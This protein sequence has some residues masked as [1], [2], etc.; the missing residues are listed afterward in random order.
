MTIIIKFHEG[1]KEVWH[2]MP[3]QDLSSEIRRILWVLIRE[4]LDEIETYE[5]EEASSGSVD[6]VR[7]LDDCYRAA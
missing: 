1:R 7:F 6:A 5:H 4:V 3:V 2:V